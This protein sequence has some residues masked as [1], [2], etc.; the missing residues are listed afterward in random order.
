MLFSQ[1][2]MQV[3]LVFW[4]VLVGLAYVTGASPVYGLIGCIFATITLLLRGW[5]KKPS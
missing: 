1:R 4:I 3:V 2:W 5:V